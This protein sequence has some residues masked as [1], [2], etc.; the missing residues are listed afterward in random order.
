[1]T[2]R[3]L[4]PR[5]EAAELSPGPAQGP[6]VFCSLE[7]SASSPRAA[8]CGTQWLLPQALGHGGPYW[9]RGSDLG[10]RVLRGHSCHLAGSTCAQG[11][12]W[13]IAWWLGLGSTPSPCLYSPPPPPTPVLIPDFAQ[14]SLQ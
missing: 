12:L 2:S 11:S 13:N 10:P 8:A 7:S 6:R 1:M 9:H 14:R 4:G 5:W 3:L